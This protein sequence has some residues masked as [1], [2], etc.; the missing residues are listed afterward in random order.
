MRNIKRTLAVLLAVLL[1]LGS[2]GALSA[3]ADGTP[4]LTFT[5][6][7]VTETVAGSGYS[8][9]G[10]ALTITAAG[11]YTVT[12][13]CSEGNIVVK[14]GVTGVTLILRDLELTCSTT[15]PLA[16]NKT[17]EVTVQIEGTVKLTDGEDPANETSTDAAVADAFEGAA[18]KAKSG[19]SLTITG[20]GSLTADGSACKN[21]VKGGATSTVTV[22]MDGTLTV[23]AANNGLAADGEVI[24]RSGK[25][26]IT[27]GNEGIKAE[28]DATDTESKGEITIS[29][30]DFT[31]NA[32]SDGIQATNLITITGGTFA[33]NAQRDGIQSNGN[34]VI[35]DGVF[36]I[37]T[38]GGYQSTGFNEDT[39][40]CKGLKASATDE[41]V[42]NATN[43]ITI[44]GGTFSLNTRDDAV[45]SDGYIYV[46]SGSFDIY[47]GD[48]GM[49]A[50][51]ELHIGAEGCAARD[52]DIRVNASYEGLEAGNLFIYGGRS[53]VVASDDGINAAGG[54][55]DNFNPWNPGGPGG[56]GGG[57]WNPG[58]PGPGGG[59]GDY[60]I[61]I[62]GGSVYVN[63]N[64]DGLDS[65]GTL[66]LTG[67]VIEVWSMSSG[68]NSP[69]D[70]DGTLT[71]K[72][73]TVFAAGAKGVDGYP[74]PQGGQTYKNYT[75]GLSITANKVVTI[76]NGTTTVFQTK[77][78]KSAQFVFYS[79]PGMSTS[80]TCS[81]ATGSVS[82]AVGDSWSHSWNE[83]V[84]TT[85]ATTEAAGVTTYT[86]TVCGATETQTIP[87]LAT[88]A[89][90]GPDPE[91][92][93]GFAVTFTADEGCCLDV[94]ATQDLTGEVVLGL[95]P[96][97]FGTDVSHNGTTGE[98]DSTGDGQVNF[99][100]EVENGYELDAVTATEGTYKNIKLVAAEGNT[101][102]YRV[103]KITAATTVAVT[104]R[105]A[106]SG[107]EEDP[108]DAFAVT[109]TADEHCEIRVY[110][111]QTMSGEAD[112]VIAAGETGTVYARDTQGKLDN[113]GNG[114]VNFV[115][116]PTDGYETDEVNAT[117]SYKNLK[118]PDE[119]GVENG[120][121]IT[122]I[123]AG[124]VAVVVTA[125]EIEADPCADGHDWG[126]PE[127]V[128]AEDYSSC[129]ATRVCKNDDT[130][131]ETE[132]AQAAGVVTKPATEEEEGKIIYTAVFE[133]E[134][135]GMQEKAVAI[136]KLEKPPVTFTDVADDAYYADAVAWAVANGI[137]NGTSATTFSPDK[138]CTRGQ[139]VTFLWRANGSPEP[140]GVELGENELPISS[141]NACPFTDV[142]ESAY[143]YKAVLWAVANGVTAGTSATTF[144]PDKPCTRGQ[145]VTF[146]WRAA[147][148]P[149]PTATECPFK[150][151][152]AGAYYE[153]AV[154]WAVE[155]GITNGTGATTFSPD[156]TCTRGQIVTFLYRDLG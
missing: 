146:Q 82:C 30:G 83:G 37:R 149:E 56:P 92:D 35:S 155:K 42:E 134:A 19:A 145:V 106:G 98:P 101:Y 112:T 87:M 62:S 141:E 20:S 137:T 152:P 116:V 110:K 49:H 54:T 81:A 143:Y 93:E 61:N 48:D 14:K 63:C 25:L 65:N 95:A 69:L 24:V 59:G 115:V 31:I 16:C 86:C 6:D 108:S 132:T 75:S 120:W 33:I 78:P 55:G 128:W 40:S 113:S 119:T 13:S 156:K 67:G 2:L 80:W 4:V 85:E 105:K 89:G 66:N 10:A 97:G 71:V 150:D 15:A 60:S 41:D 126:E 38:F 153:K 26:D 147:G 102:T 50:D 64:G 122:K 52:P 7:G 22:D 9:D 17:S 76:K 117:G 21:G 88:E 139:V 111:T 90:P 130:H 44:T 114:Q 99:V 5:A 46:K 107:E 12:G 23:K 136:P 138:P 27:A 28:P 123:T 47:S 57:G 154:L 133:N 103:T 58:Q 51:T 79:A 77:A 100:V 39:M 1:A 121:R 96:G 140:G 135:F 109:L 45:H 84:V 142:D 18:I 53:Y 29:G 32:Q 94:Y 129:T 124:D 118:G 70:C 43:T 11:V 104:T 8:I 127:Y 91:P 3:F 74:S 148:E 125:K 36:D 34:L 73:A 68:D 144:S 72:G 131:V 151:V